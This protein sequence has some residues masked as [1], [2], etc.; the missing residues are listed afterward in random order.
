MGIGD[1]KHHIEGANHQR[2]SKGL[3]HQSCLSFTSTEDPIRKKVNNILLCALSEMGLFLYYLPSQVECAEVKMS[4]LLA[5]HNIPLALADHLSPLMIHLMVTLLKAM[6][7]QKQKHCVCAKKK[8]SFILN[9]AVATEF[10]AE[11]VTTM[12]SIIQCWWIERH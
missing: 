11:L 6:Y 8:T 2:V 3:E 12:Q 9:G 1:V 7:V 4:I 10:K 5:Q